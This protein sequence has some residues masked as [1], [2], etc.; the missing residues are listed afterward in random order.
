MYP[1]PGKLGFLNQLFSLISNR[2]LK[3][4]KS[5]SQIPSS[6]V[7]AETMGVYQYICAH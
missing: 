5:I 1:Q 3:L 6:A 7:M 4:G 2:S